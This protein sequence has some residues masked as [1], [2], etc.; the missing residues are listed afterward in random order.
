MKFII[1]PEVF[2][3]A[4]NLVLRDDKYPN[5]SCTA[6]SEIV[7]CD[8]CDRYERHLNHWR[9]LHRDDSG[10]FFTDYEDDQTIERRRFRVQLLRECAFNLREHGY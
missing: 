2:E 7:K 8:W 4:A 10:W 3:K 6:I 5:M 9:L 1:D